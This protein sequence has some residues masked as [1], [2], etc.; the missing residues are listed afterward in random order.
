MAGVVHIPWYATLFRG[1]RFAAAIAEPAAAALRYNA[2]R[3][4]VHRSRDDAYRFDHMIWFEDKLD[5]LR[6]WEGPE[7]SHFRASYSGWYQV[8]VLYYWADEVVFDAIEESGV[9]AAAT[10]EPAPSA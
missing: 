4:T 10:P 6:Y 7:M 5:W 9:D 8:P 2:T 1:D 3:Y